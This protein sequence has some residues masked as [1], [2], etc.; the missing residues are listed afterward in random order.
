MLRHYGIEYIVRKARWLTR[1]AYLVLIPV[2]QIVQWVVCNNSR[3]VE[4]G[5]QECLSLYPARVADTP[6]S[7][8]GVNGEITTILGRGPSIVESIDVGRERFDLPLAEGIRSGARHSVS[9]IELVQNIQ[10]SSR[11]IGPS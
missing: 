11:L 9:M 7:S 5:R 3:I 4:Q 2:E 1:D 6:E 8:S 10:N